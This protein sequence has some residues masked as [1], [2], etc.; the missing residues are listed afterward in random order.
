[1][2]KKADK[3][4]GARPTAIVKLADSENEGKRNWLVYADSGVGKTVLAGTAP[5]N[6]FLTV[7]AAGTE[8]AK[9]FGS[10]SDEL[11]IDT[12]QKLEEAYEYFK[13]GSGCDDY[14]WVTLDSLSEIEQVAFEDVLTA[15]HKKNP[16][17]SLDIPAQPDYQEV[18]IRMRKLVNRWNRLPV[19]VLYT[20][21]AMR[22]AT[23]DEDGDDST[24]LLPLVGSSKNGKVSQ[25]ICGM[26]TLV[27]YLTALDPE[28]DEEV[29]ARRLWTSA[30]ERMFAKDRHDAFGRYVDRAN[31]ES[32]AERVLE[33]QS[34][35][36]KSEVDRKKKAPV[37]KTAKKKENT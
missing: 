22:L 1:M 15:A 35:G 18:Y 5:N 23:V 30:T 11:Q 10:T 31:V 2:A 28:E 12:W 36:G 32:M 26:V 3:T 17:R 19:N 37:K 6:L 24:L 20:A 29:G 8:S 14:S 13:Y 7:E 21:H 16:N 4:S 9:A 33:R 34:E 25:Q 27:G